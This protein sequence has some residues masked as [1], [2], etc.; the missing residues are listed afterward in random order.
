MWNPPAIPARQASLVAVPSSSPV[1]YVTVPRLRDADREQLARVRREAAGPAVAIAARLGSRATCHA[2]QSAC[3][4]IRLR[5]SPPPSPPPPLTRV[6]VDGHIARSRGESAPLLE[7]G[8]PT[9][10]HAHIPLRARALRLPC[11]SSSQR[12]WRIDRV[13]PARPLPRARSRRRATR[14]P[15]EPSRA[16]RRSHS[17]T[18]P[19]EIFRNFWWAFDRGRLPHFFCIKMGGGVSCDL[20]VCSA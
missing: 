6:N 14:Y 7:R 19:L 4:S 8:A 2:G 11:P 15:R 16:R 17:P 18:S 5:E 10:G 1:T 3:A 20:G 12:P 13:R 9:V